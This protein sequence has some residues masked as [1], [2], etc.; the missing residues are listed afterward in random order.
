[1]K[2]VILTRVSTKDQEEGH[3][4]PAQNTRLLGYCKRK[5]LEVVKSFQIIESSTRGKRKE[6]MQMIDFCKKQKETICIVADAVDRVQRSFKESVML[7]E[8]IRKEKIELHFYRENMV[9]GKGSSSSDIMRWDFSV[10]GA[11]SYVLQLSENVK[12]SLDFKFKNGECIGF[13]PHGYENYTD[14]NGKNS[15][16]LKEPD[17]SKIKSLFELYSLGG[18]SL[19]ELARYSNEIGLT[20]KAGKK[21]SKSTIAYI[22]DNPFYYGEL[23][24]KGKKTVHIYPRLIKKTLWD[25]CQEVRK[26]S[27]KKPFKHSEIPF[28]Y[29][30]IFTCMNSG[31][32]CPCEIKKQKF[33]YVAC[34]KS[35]G[36]R[37]YI[38]EQDITDQI[39]YILNGIAIPSDVLVCLKE[40]LKK[41]KDAE[42]EFRNRE[43]G[44]INAQIT[45]AKARLDKLF[46]MRLDD[47]IDRETYET[48]KYELQV[49]IESYNEKLQLHSNADDKFNDTVISLFEIASQSG[50]LFE[51]SKDIET[52]RLLLRFVFD[53]LQI[54]EGVVH[55]KLRFPFSEMEQNLSTNNNNNEPLKI[56]NLGQK[57]PVLTG[58]SKME[59]SNFEKS[60]KIKEIDPSIS[61]SGQNGWGGWI[62]T[63]GWR[64]QNP[65]P[66]HLATPQ[67]TISYLLPFCINCKFF[68]NLPQ[69]DC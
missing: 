56:N 8:L 40:H 65:L 55:Y 33:T 69:I 28:L 43:I 32:I 30:G 61:I 64:N 44:N 67:Q 24:V 17:A 57:T 41:S 26:A 14:E 13:A 4:L 66:Y 7:D 62:R 19:H 11:K 49:S 39:V 63:N 60:F 12:R 36:K 59:D 34:Y 1:M 3:S 68:F 23:N 6:F 51:H 53:K 35:N 54:K 50:Y 37:M 15:V 38:S 47:E 18:T 10:M 52:K 2:A 31:R 48:K 9:I 5:G 42:I 25:K 46:N 45:K 58:M 21:L 22:I 16:R 29:R 20:S 27:D